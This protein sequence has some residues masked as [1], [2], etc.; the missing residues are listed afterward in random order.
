ME[1][2]ISGIFIVIVLLGCTN[3]NNKSENHKRL[4]ELLDSHFQLDSSNINGLVLILN[5]GCGPCIEKSLKWIELHKNCFD[6]NYLFISSNH[7]FY[8][9]IENMNLH[10]IYDSTQFIDK[11][12]FEIYN[13]SILYKLGTENLNLR[14]INVDEMDKIDEIFKN[15][16]CND[17]SSVFKN[18]ESKD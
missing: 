10:V 17:S 4:Y 14:S 12:Y 11:I 2:L 13:V 7:D 16:L 8:T 1:R 6:E 15:I 18:Q 5:Y 3:A 9:R